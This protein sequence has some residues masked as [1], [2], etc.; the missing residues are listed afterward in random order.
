MLSCRGLLW[1]IDL[2]S[3]G[4]LGEGLVVEE[5]VAVGRMLLGA[6]LIPCLVVLL[7]STWTWRGLCC[8]CWP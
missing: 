8:T 7:L 4:R 6:E 1:R 2:D 3:L 5:V